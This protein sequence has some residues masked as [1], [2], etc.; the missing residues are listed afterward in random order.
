[1]PGKRENAEKQNKAI[2]DAF[3]HFRKLYEKCKIDDEFSF[4]LRCEN[5]D[6]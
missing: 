6:S 2:K 4:L 5:N 1:M 3:L